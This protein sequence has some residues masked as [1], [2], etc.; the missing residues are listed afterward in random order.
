MVKI[1]TLLVVED[2]P[3]IALAMEIVLTKAGFA[4]C[5]I[6]PSGEKAI[7]AAMLEK[8]DVILMDIRL[9]GEIDGIEAACKIREHSDTPIIFMTGYQDKTTRARAQA[10]SPLAFLEKPVKLQDLQS[11]LASAGMGPP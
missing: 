9:A 1:A 8:P 2:E 7:E 11:I 5:M 10:L 6:V 4:V 3:I